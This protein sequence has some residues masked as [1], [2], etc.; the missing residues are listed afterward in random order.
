MLSVPKQTKYFTDKL[1]QE[2]NVRGSKLFEFQ[3]LIKIGKQIN[4]QV[5]DFNLFID[6]L[7][8]QNVIIKKSNKLYEFM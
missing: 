8:M 6:K 1:R 5:G 7:N 4:L 2:V 3:E